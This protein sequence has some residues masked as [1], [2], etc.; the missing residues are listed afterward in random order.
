MFH[1]FILLFLWC[2]PVFGGIYL[3]DNLQR[4]EQGDFIVTAQNKTCTV[5]HVYEKDKNILTLE[6]VSLPAPRAKMVVGSWR[7]WIQAGAPGHTSWIMYT[8]NLLNG[9]VEKCFSFSKNRW[10]D[11]SAT[12]N[13]LGK[14][15]NL[16][17]KLVP[18]NERKKVGIS[19]GPPSQDRRRLWQPK[20]IVDGMVIP[21][22]PFNAWRTRWPN[23][24]SPI[25]G[26]KIE[27]YVPAENS[28]YPAYFPYWL[29]IHGTLGKAQLR[30][31]DSGKG[32]ISPKPPLIKLEAGQL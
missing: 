6:E 22:V 1:F 10:C 11:P 2:S 27:V 18:L 29:Q 8:V 7:S 15:L 17:L 25:S 19:S 5:L 14:L 30:V 12:E 9:S 13:F 26:K 4:A 32:L 21:G 28:P 16:H 24:S 23:D 31:I 20:L 3:R